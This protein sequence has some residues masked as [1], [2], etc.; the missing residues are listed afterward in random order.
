[1]SSDVP[2]MRVNNYALM[3]DVIRRWSTGELTRPST[4]GEMILQ[5]AEEEITVI[6][7]DNW[8]DETKDVAVNFIELPDGVLNVTLPS[9]VMLGRADAAVAAQQGRY[10]F[11]MEYDS[12]YDGD[13]KTIL[14]SDDRQRIQRARLADYCI[15]ICM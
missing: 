2:F 15:S 12:A 7:S 10:P 3:G 1:M 5:L 11:P 13:P 6:G 14:P 4:I 9:E 8:T